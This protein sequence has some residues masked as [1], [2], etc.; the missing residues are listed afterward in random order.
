MVT[1]TFVTVVRIYNKKS[2][3]LVETIRRELEQYGCIPK[4]LMCGCSDGMLASSLNRAC[5]HGSACIFTVVRVFSQ[6]RVYFHCGA[7]VFR[8]ARVFSQKRACFHRSAGV[9]TEPSVC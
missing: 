5:F 1:T 8:A 6:L 9:F 2:A 3:K 7:R 4:Q